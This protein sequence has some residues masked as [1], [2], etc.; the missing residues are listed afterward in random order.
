MGARKDKVKTSAG[1]ERRGPDGEQ[2]PHPRGGKKGGSGKREK[3]IRLFGSSFGG[4]EK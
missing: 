2:W 3:M 4:R 1:E